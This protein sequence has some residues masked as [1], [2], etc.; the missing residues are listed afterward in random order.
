M[1]EGPEKKI[2]WRTCI[3]AT[4][5]MFKNVV[6]N[7]F[8]TETDAFESDAVVDAID[9]IF[10]RV[11]ARVDDNLKH[12]SWIDKK[13]KKAALKKSKRILP[14]IGFPESLENVS[15]LE[16]LFASVEIRSNYLETMLSYTKNKYAPSKLWAKLERH[17][18]DHAWLS[19]PYKINAF[20][21]A[22]MNQ[23]LI[24]YGILQQPFFEHGRSMAL[25]YGGIGFT[26]GHELSHAFDDNGRLYDGHG[27]KRNWWTAG[28][29][30][31]FKEQKKCLEYQFGNNTLFGHLINGKNTIGETIADNGGLAAA[32]KAFS[33]LKQN[34][35][36]QT[37]FTPEQLFFIGYGQVWCGN[38]T[39]RYEIEKIQ[40]DPHPPSKVRVNVAVGNSKDFSTVFKCPVGSPMN[41]KMKCN[42]WK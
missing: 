38:N 16:K 37:E 29:E 1:P 34:L 30:K 4:Q 5:D 7:M 26:I 40:K 25:N 22:A 13:T 14:L 36:E 11:H 21:A 23:I 12:A 41:P 10:E 19:A 35:T 31:G 39:D 32:W 42:I 15:K 8:L 24:P 20:Y 18:P 27:N 3:K 2:T 17:V 6:S 28:A 33:A 9:D